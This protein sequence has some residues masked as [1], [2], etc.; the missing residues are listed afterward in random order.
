MFNYSVDTAGIGL[1]APPV[2]RRTVQ[3]QRE[4]P[5]RS[6]RGKWDVLTTLR[7]FTKDIDE[8]RAK[9][10]KDI[11]EEKF[12]FDNKPHDVDII[13]GNMLMANGACALWQYALSLG[14][15]S[16]NNALGSGPTYLNNAQTSLY[17]GDGSASNGAGGTASITN[18]SA[19]LTFGTSQS[20]LQGKYFFD[21]GD[22]T[23]AFYPIISG[24]TT[25]WTLGANYGG[26][27]LSGDTNWLVMASESHNQTAL[28]GSSNVAHQ[29]MDGGFPAN[30]T[31]A[32]M[33]AITAATNATPIVLTISGGD[34]STN[35]IVQVY[36]VNGN[37]A[38]NGMWV[39]NPASSS[40]VTLLN[41]VGN[42]AWTY[43]GF[44]TKLSVMKFQATFGSS[45][46]N[47][48]WYEW[49]IFNGTGGNKVMINRKVFNG[50]TK[51]G[52][53]TA[54]GVS[55]GIG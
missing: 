10:G 38:A 24:S 29:G 13:P 45:S 54:L 51:S 8:Y 26:T 3:P 17:V 41:S 47:F 44:V 31:S 27:T 32:Q 20:G 19:S 50:G 7:R 34:I 23:H 16:A 55:I 37:T 42:S 12:F 22:S 9:H 4:V 43:G 14:S 46:A 33:N 49:G 40:S 2:R 25:S 53:S 39:A 18:G 48:A 52:G 36:E 28:S 21:T 11:G 15:A 6:D 30:S 35:D 5:S 1:A